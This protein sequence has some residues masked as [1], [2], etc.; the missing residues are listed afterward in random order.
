LSERAKDNARLLDRIRTLHAESDGVLGSPRICEDLRFE[1]EGCSRN[2]VA[3]LMRLNAIRGIPSN[4]IQTPPEAGRTI[5]EIGDPQL[6][7]AVWPKPCI[8]FGNGAI[9]APSLVATKRRAG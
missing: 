1:G 4:V 8:R 2:R 3:R 6:I 5:R 9:A 7:G